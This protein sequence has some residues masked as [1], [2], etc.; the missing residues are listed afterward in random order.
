MRWRGMG[1]MVPFVLLGVM[2][3]ISVLGEPYA[4]PWWRDPRFW[5]IT[6]LGIL[7]A[8]LPL[9]VFGVLLNRR[10]SDSHGNSPHDFFSIPVEAWGILA[11]G[12]GV[13]AQLVGGVV[14]IGN[15]VRPLPSPEEAMIAQQLEFLKHPDQATRESAVRKL[16][17][18]GSEARAVVPALTATLNDSNAKVRL[19]AEEA[20]AVLEPDGMSARSFQVRKSVMVLVKAK[21]DSVNNRML[22]SERLERVDD[23]FAAETRDIDLLWR[24]SSRHWLPASEYAKSHARQ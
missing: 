19:A 7:V 3:Y 24:K 2:I 17:K 12:L 15:L 1:F 5:C 4:R 14:V 20:L 9:L 21:F 22:P 13:L 18:F 11:I 16:S 10:R 23:K 6:G 8:G